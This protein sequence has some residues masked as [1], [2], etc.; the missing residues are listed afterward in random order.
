MFFGLV[1]KDI[2]INSKEAKRNFFSDYEQVLV[3]DRLLEYIS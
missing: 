2:K 3:M 1:C